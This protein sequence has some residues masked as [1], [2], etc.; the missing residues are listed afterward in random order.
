[1]SKLKPEY[2]YPF[3]DPKVYEKYIDKLKQKIVCDEY[4]HDAVKLIGV[5]SALSSFM[6]F[7][8][9]KSI[10]AKYDNLKFGSKNIGNVNYSVSII[11]ASEIRSVKGDKVNNEFLKVKTKIYNEI[12]H[13]NFSLYS[14]EDYS[15][16]IK[17]VIFDLLLRYPLK[18][19]IYEESEINN[20]VGE[21]IFPLIE[22]HE[23]KIIKNNIEEFKIPIGNGL[24]SIN[25]NYKKL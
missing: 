12:K 20:I 15:D 6:F 10:Q 4:E 16:V 17:S 3:T 13:D 23:E 9:R 7:N 1:M 25:V 8:N 21:F 2:T 22:M 18:E 11:P 24:F 19:E 5:L 14:K